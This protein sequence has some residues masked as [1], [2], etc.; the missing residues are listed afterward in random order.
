MSNRIKAGDLR[1]RVKLQKPVFTTNERGMRIPTWETVRDVMAGKRDV[2][3]REF[4]IAQAY[5]A[6]KT[7]TFVIRWRDDVTTQWR[8]VHNGVSYN[9]MEVNHL[10]YMRDYMHLKCE[11]VTGEGA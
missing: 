1:L 8:V 11:A 3:G 10:G 9:I 7:V 6:E 4:Y 5:N 2:S